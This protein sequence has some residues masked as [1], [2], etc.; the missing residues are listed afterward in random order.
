M[1]TQTQSAIEYEAKIYFL[2]QQVIEMDYV[3]ET[4]YA[5]CKDV[6]HRVKILSFSVFCLAIAIICINFT[7][8]GW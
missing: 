3:I 8:R 2:Q 5:D 4:I 7:I 6:V 1:D